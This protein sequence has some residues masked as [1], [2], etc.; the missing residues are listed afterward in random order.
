[1]VLVRDAAGLES[2]RS[3]PSEI[4]AAPALTL[5]TLNLGLLATRPLGLWQI[6]L[7][8]HVN[9]RLV[10]TPAH[11]RGIEADVIAL[12]EVYSERHRRFLKD[13]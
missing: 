12:Q 11:L 5:L 13:S 6:C 7:A 4:D 1:M 3:D 9:E 10:A 8:P 2:C